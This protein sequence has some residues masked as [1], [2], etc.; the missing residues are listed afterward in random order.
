[1]VAGQFVHVVVDVEFRSG[2]SLT[3]SAE[4]ALDCEM[5]QLHEHCSVHFR[6]NH[7]HGGCQMGIV[8]LWIVAPVGAVNL[9]LLAEILDKP[10]IVA[11]E[12][13]IFV[14]KRG[15]YFHGPLDHVGDQ[16]HR[17][18]PPRNQMV[19]AAMML[20][21]GKNARKYR[22]NPIDRHQIFMFLAG[23]PQTFDH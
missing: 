6:T 19:G 14:G 18:R 16:C 7:G 2:P 17:W 10:P 5:C 15:I 3:F 13:V 20:G 22:R 23:Q 8:E 12:C 11:N 21:L 4:I 1:M 9:D